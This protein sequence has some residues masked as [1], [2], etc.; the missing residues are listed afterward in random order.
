MI[1]GV[2]AGIAEKYKWDPS[3]VRLVAVLGTVFTGFWLGIIMYIA[4]AIIIPDISR[5]VQ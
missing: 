1:S 5:K 3:V 4:A 2:C